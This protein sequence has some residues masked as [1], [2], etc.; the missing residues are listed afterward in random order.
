MT[1]VCRPQVSTAKSRRESFARRVMSPP[2]LAPA[3]GGRPPGSTS[4]AIRPRA[5]P[6]RSPS[7]WRGRCGGV[8]PCSNRSPVL[9]IPRRTKSGTGTTSTAY[10]DR[11]LPLPVLGMVRA[12]RPLPESGSATKPKPV[13]AQEVRFMS[14]YG[15]SQERQ[16]RPVQ[17]VLSHQD[18]HHWHWFS[19]SSLSPVT[20]C[21][22]A[23]SGSGERVSGGAARIA[24][25]D[26]QCTVRSRSAPSASEERTS[27]VSVSAEPVTLICEHRG[28]G[29]RRK[30]VKRSI[31]APAEQLSAAASL[32]TT[33]FACACL[34][35]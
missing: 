10:C 33:R 19:M 2:A 25:I 34:G 35:Y 30:S 5:L 15:D 13:S 28:N 32:G 26:S 3:E 16:K 11:L 9:A 21:S 31:A 12:G 4:F 24:S 6:F 20:G 8:A 7:Y 23:E 18:E 27:L 29:L 17:P 1:P 14:M 22:N